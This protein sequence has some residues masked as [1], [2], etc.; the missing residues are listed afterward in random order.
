MWKLTYDKENILL[1]KE[2]ITLANFKANYPLLAWRNFGVV[3]HDITSENENT[4]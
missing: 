3:I 2:E 1:K 4:I